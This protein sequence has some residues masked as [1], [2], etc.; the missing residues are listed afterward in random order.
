MQSGTYVA[1]FQRNIPASNLQPSKWRQ[2]IFSDEWQ[3]LYV[4]L[5]DFTF[6]KAKSCIWELI[7]ICFKRT[8]Q[9]RLESWEFLFLQWDFENFTNYPLTEKNPTRCNSV[10]NFIITYFKW[11]STC[12][13]RHTT[14]RQEPETAQAASGFCVRGRMSDVQFLDVVR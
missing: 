8:L 3:H 6:K 9:L 13:R 7:K 14:H 2:Q 1:T 12:F 5:N 11:S 10:P 4:K